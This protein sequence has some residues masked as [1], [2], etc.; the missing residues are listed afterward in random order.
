MVFDRRQR[1]PQRVSDLRVAAPVKDK[2]GHFALAWCQRR[3]IRPGR[4]LNDADQW[5]AYLAAGGQIYP[6]IRPGLCQIR[7]RLKRAGGQRVGRLIP[8][9]ANSPLQR[10]KSFSINTHL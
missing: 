6:Q 8:Q 3:Q 7:Q 1:D 2:P 9:S 10:Y 4:C 5:R